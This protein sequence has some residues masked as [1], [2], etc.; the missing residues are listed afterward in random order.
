MR[1]ALLLPL[2]I[3]TFIAFIN[4]VHSE[5][6]VN[7]NCD[8]IVS[9][10]L[11]RHW[12]LWCNEAELWGEYGIFVGYP[13]GVHVVEIKRALTFEGFKIHIESFYYGDYAEQPYIYVQLPT[14]VEIG[15]KKPEHG[16][17]LTI[18]LK[19]TN[20][21]VYE[22][23][24]SE[25]Y[26]MPDGGA[27]KWI[28]Y[29]DPEYLIVGLILEPRQP[30]EPGQ[31]QTP[32]INLDCGYNIF[33]W[34][35]SL[36]AILSA[37]TQ[38]FSHGFTIITTTATF[39]IQLSPLL[40]TL[41]PLMIIIVLVEDPTALPKV[42]DAFVGLGKKIYDIVMKIIHAIVDLIGHIVPT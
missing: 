38:M 31:T 36:F 20:E 6:M 23:V 15:G 7:T 42:I 22:I 37:V 21:S 17:K 19:S 33:C 18:Y 27:S 26:L 34:I 41:I 25:A 39:L 1:R 32:Q 13:E 8:I 30:T 5:Y 28:I 24:K 14:Y 35:S 4:V 11:T 12:V 3:L 40:I 9:D 29:V 10:Y 2:I 16:F